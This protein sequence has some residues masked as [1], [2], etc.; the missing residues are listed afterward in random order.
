MHFDKDECLSRAKELADAGDEASIRYACLELRMCIEAIVYAKLRTYEKRLPDSAFTKWQPDKAMKA[1]LAIEPEA[2]KD[3]QLVL[4]SEDEAGRPSGVPIAFNH[5]A[6]PVALIRKYYHRLGSYLHVPTGRRSVNLDDQRAWIEKLRTTLDELTAA[7]EPIVECSFDSSIAQVASYSCAVCETELVFNP[8]GA[9]ESGRVE[10]LS[11]EARY[12]VSVPDDAPGRLR[13]E[14]D[15]ASFDC[16]MCDTTG[17]VE[18]R[19]LALGYE[20]R[21]DSCR[22]PFRVTACNWGFSVVQDSAE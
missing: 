6:L 16:E 7:L 21:C 14:L 22:A 11:C 18:R 1:L 8:E 17:R 3:H 12:N 5:K 2:D 4:Y 9:R 15:A 13:I 20:F 19:H 10:C